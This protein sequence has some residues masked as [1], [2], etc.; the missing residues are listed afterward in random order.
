MHRPGL[1]SNLLTP[2]CYL[3]GKGWAVTEPSWISRSNHLGN[4]TCHR[5]SD[6]VTSPTESF[7]SFN[8]DLSR[9][10]LD[11]RVWDS[12]FEASCFNV[13]L[14]LNGFVWADSSLSQLILRPTSS[15]TQQDVTKPKMSTTSHQ[16]LTALSSSMLGLS[17]IAIG[18]RFYARSVHKAALKAD[19]WMMIPTLVRHLVRS[20]RPLFAELTWRIQLFLAATTGTTFYG[21]QLCL[22]HKLRTR[23]TSAYVKSGLQKKVLGYPTP[24]DH[25]IPVATAAMTSKVLHPQPLMALY[26]YLIGAQLY[27]AFDWFSMATLGCIKLSALFF[28][29]RIFCVGH[30][31]R[32][33]FRRLILV[34]VIVIVLWTCAFMIL[35]GLQCGTHFSAL[36]INADY[37]KYCH[38]SYPYLLGFAISDFLL[39][40]WIICLPIP[41]V[42]PRIVTWGDWS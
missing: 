16:G 20:L 35:T 13:L 40:L 1:W 8:S 18:L 10:H 14:P 6:E 37:K 7:S 28:Y 17:I 11:S 33:V 30:S 29:H 5:N 42:R 25:K 19:D 21:E 27:M 4:D 39:D 26:S 41:Q 9:E 2:A 38:I 12:D 24:T 22:N 3:H 31:S 15:E 23:D 32:S 36:W 34:S